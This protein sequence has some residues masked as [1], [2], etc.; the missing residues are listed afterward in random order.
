MGQ[1]NESGRLA[2]NDRSGAF[3]NIPTVDLAAEPPDPALVVPG[4]AHRYAAG[5]FLPWRC[6]G[7]VLF[8]V[9]ASSEPVAL[10]RIASAFSYPIAFVRAEAAAIRACIEARFQPQFAHDAVFRLDEAQPWFSARRTVT[11][12]QSMTFAC[13][14]AGAVGLAIPAPHI[15]MAVLA[16]MLSAGFLLNVL[17]RGLLVWVGASNAR[18]STDARDA[19][20]L[21]DT[22]LPLYSVLVPLYHE[23]DVL[24]SLI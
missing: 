5:T 9:T 7:G 20:P 16:A 11:P 19:A 6:R 23:A 18:G 22:A 2:A 12:A 21:P 17:F 3:W 24:P 8:V 1:I 10:A 13:L 15:A 4:L 14:F